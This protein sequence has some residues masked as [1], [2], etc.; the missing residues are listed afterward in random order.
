MPERTREQASYN[1]RQQD[2]ASDLEDKAATNGLTAFSF[3]AIV[4]SLAPTTPMKGYL[5]AFLAAL[6]LAFPILSQGE[7]L[8]AEAAPMLAPGNLCYIPVRS[9]GWLHSKKSG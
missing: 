9:S 2:L 8:R 4:A 1:R 3:F 5:Y 7:L 6:C